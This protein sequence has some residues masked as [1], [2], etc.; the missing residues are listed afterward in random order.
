[1][2]V[3]QGRLRV[4]VLRLHLAAVAVVVV[5]TVPV[6]RQV[7]TVALVVAAVLRLPV[8]TVLAVRV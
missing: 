2:P 8:R 4:L 5:L 6:S 1:M 7:I 3:S